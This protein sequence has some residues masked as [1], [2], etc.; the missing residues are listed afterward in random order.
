MPG[1]FLLEKI[2]GLSLWQLVAKMIKKT[3]FNMNHL[4]GLLP[5]LSYNASL[6]EYDCFY[7]S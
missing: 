6:I 7:T 3:T 2:K 4:R 5:V 1:D